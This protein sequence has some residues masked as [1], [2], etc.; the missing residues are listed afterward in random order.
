M[1]GAGLANWMEQPH[2]RW[3]FRHVRELMPSARIPARRPTQL[4][5]EPADGLL[6]LGYTTPTGEAQTVRE[7]IDESHTD[8]LVVLSRGRV[9]F[10]WYAPGVKDDDRHINFSVS[11]SITALLAGALAGAGKLDFNAGVSE[12]VPE[13]KASGYGDATVRHLL[14]MSASVDFVE[15]YLLGEEVMLRYRRAA[16]WAPGATG[17]GLHAFLCDL[18]HDGGAHGDRFNYLSPTTDMLGW[19]CERA[20]G[21]A[22]AVAVAEEIWTPMGAEADAEVTL[23]LHGAARAA[24]GISS[25]TRDIARVGQLVLEGG[26]DVLPGW[27]VEDLFHGGDH[28]QWD[29]GEI[30]DWFPG[31][32]YRSCWFAIDPALQ[33]LCALGIHGQ[34]IYV[35]RPRQVVVAKQ[36]C[37]PDASDQ[38][39]THSDTAAA[40][41]LSSAVS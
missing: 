23:D 7:Y 20:S 1:E 3:A 34:M 27:F 15:D 32:A 11:K 41:A 19:V 22:F 36:S 24:G 9:V 35:D 31:G 28:A 2:S 4:E 33:L 6:D 21:K 25:T 29:A 18:P 5:R 13:A 40:A 16:N 26:R 14:D 12:Y 17:E 37:W 10:E 38:A 30:A 8:A 39:R